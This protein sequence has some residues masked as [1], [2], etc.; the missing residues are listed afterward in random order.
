M[1]VLSDHPGKVVVTVDEG[2]TVE[3]LEGAIECGLLHDRR[4]LKSLCRSMASHVVR[5]SLPKSH[6]R[7]A[8]SS[9]PRCRMTSRPPRSR[10]PAS[11]RATFPASAMT[12]DAARPDPRRL[13]D[14]ALVIA[15]ID[16]VVLVLVGE[17]EAEAD[18][19]PRRR[20]RRC[21]RRGRSACRASRGDRARGRTGPRRRRRRRPRRQ[22]RGSPR[23]WHCAAC[24]RACAHWHA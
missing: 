24:R 10:A 15:E 7:R 19:L 21:K 23:R 22:R 5:V 2:H 1:A 16:V 12:G 8:G 17:V 13:G 9:R 4:V 11:A 6:R 3:E 14:I 20:G 18:M